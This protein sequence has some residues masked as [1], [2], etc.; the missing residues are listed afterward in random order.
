MKTQSEIDEINRKRKEALELLQQAKRIM[1][2]TG[3]SLGGETIREC[4]STLIEDGC[5]EY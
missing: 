5:D 3:C 2:N 4:V 1:E